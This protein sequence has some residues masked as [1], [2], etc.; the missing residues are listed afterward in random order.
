VFLL[1]LYTTCRRLTW[2][3]RFPKYNMT[4]CGILSRQEKKKAPRLYLEDRREPGKASL[5]TLRVGSSL[6]RL[7]LLNPGVISFP[8]FTDIRPDMKIVGGSGSQSRRDC[9][10]HS[11]AY[12]FPGP[13]RG[14]YN[15][16]GVTL[17][18]FESRE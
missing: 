9:T 6:W 5:W 11:Y 1:H 18:E 12:A 16:S 14:A 17:Y 2:I 3:H 8:V 4:R 13:R 15:L 7:H 10:N